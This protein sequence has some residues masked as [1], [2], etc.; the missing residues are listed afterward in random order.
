MIN[1]EQ[2]KEKVAVLGAEPQEAEALCRTIE[3]GAYRT[4]VFG[5][6]DGLKATLGS[7]A[8]LAAILDL[9]SIPMDNRRVRDLASSFPATHFLAISGERFH[10]ELQ[11][12][13]RDHLFACLNKPVDP[14]EL[15]YFL[16]CI[17]DNRTE[18]RG[19]PDGSQ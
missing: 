2:L 6:V 5:D 7:G 12:A 19:P 10:P 8:Y 18:S 16:R 3:T 1:N 14:D 9:D 15:H 13:I 11:E 17:R 4:V